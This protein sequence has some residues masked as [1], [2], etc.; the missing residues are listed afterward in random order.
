[1][2][3]AAQQGLEEQAKKVLSVA[4][5]SDGPAA[6]RSSIFSLDYD[7]GRFGNGAQAHNG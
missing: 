6:G 5:K 3:G 4:R 7:A 1:L 2:D